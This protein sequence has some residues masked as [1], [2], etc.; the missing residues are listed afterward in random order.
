MHN[1]VRLE[2]YM[3]GLEDTEI[4]KEEGVARSTVTMWRNR[5]NLK[6]NLAVHPSDKLIASSNIMELFNKGLSDIELSDAIG[7]STGKVK[8]WRE[9]ENLESNMVRISR[10]KRVI[11][12]E[13]NKLGLTDT[14]ITNLTGVPLM[15]VNSKRRD[16]GLALNRGSRIERFKEL[17]REGLTDME[18]ANET[19]YD[20]ASVASWRTKDGLPNNSKS[21]LEEL[22]GEGHN[23]KDIADITGYTEIGI[24]NLISNL[25][26]KDLNNT[27]KPSQSIKSSKSIKSIKPNREEVQECQ[28]ENT[29][30]I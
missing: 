18:I 15:T 24:R 28:M 17:Y 21:R 25:I 22:L 20:Y 12:S 9:S 19:G 23:K 27:T 26:G 8:Q 1:E 4:A 30:F 13:L 7:V 16:A 14:Q 11:I 2:L 3:E 10:E 5:N 29:R 6:P